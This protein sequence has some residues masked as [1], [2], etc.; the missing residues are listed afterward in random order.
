MTNK[1]RY[2]VIIEPDLLAQLTEYRHKCGITSQ[3]KAIQ[4]LLYSALNMKKE[5]STL[6]IE[7]G[8]SKKP[9]PMTEA[10][11]DHQE[12]ELIRIARELD[13]SQKALLLRLVETAVENGGKRRRQASPDV[14]RN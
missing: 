12:R 3:S 8:K 4:I 10:G 2:S 1:Q 9:D 13:P 14:L 7:S 6:E 5:A 11:L